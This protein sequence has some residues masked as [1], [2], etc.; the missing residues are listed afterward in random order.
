[1]PKMATA[2]PSTLKKAGNVVSLVEEEKCT[3]LSVIVQLS[4]FQ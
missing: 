4:V 2:F 1:L 3:P